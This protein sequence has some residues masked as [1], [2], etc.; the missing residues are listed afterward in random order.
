MVSFV[1]SKGNILCRLIKIE[2]YEIFAIINRAIKGLHCSMPIKHMWLIKLLDTLS[3]WFY[4]S[5]PPDIRRFNHA[6]VKSS[7]LVFVSKHSYI[8]KYVNHL[9]LNLVTRYLFFS[10]M[11]QFLLYWTAYR[12]L[13]CLQLVLDKLILISISLVYIYCASSVETFLKPYI[14]IYAVNSC[15]ST[16]A[17]MAL[18]S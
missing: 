5:K 14:N 17:Q 18:C 10:S 13:H 16:R 9:T 1:S 2:L 12:Q 3:T 7:Y 11:G 4:R 15:G 6:A 8:V